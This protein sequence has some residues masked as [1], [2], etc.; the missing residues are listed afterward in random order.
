S[1]FTGIAWAAEHVT[2]LLG[3]ADDLNSDIDKAV[4]QYVST[5]PWNDHLDLIAGLAGA[6]VYCLERPNASRAV[7][8]LELIANRLDETAVHSAGEAWWFT[9]PDLFTQ[10]QRR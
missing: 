8:C 7:R 3:E 6:G 1:G 5:S 4:E 2:T 9:G 10:E